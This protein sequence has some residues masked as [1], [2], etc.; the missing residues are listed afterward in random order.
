VVNMLVLSEVFYLFNVRHFTASALRLD[1][2]V[3]NR[4]AL[5]AV[6]ITLALQAAFTYA[7]PMQQLF[8]SAA[9]DLASWG[10]IVALA[11]GKFMAIEVEKLVLRRL[12]VRRM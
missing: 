10:W 9:L 5:A 2:L 4:V 6:A 7:P 1:A 11:F 8:G 3:G 12:G